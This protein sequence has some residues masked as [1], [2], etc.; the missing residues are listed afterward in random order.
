MRYLLILLLALNCYADDK[1]IYLKFNTGIDD[2][3]G[4]ARLLAVGY[5]APFYKILD[6]QLEG[7]A[8]RDSHQVQSTIAYGSATLGFTVNAQSGTYAKIFAG[9]ALVSSTDSRL[10]SI[11]EFNDDLELG[12]RDKRGLAL[13][14]S[15]KHISNAGLVPPNT[16]RDFVGFK[17][18]LPF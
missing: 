5:Q 12:I 9:P 13:G 10:S 2:K 16:G 15:F 3:I 17:V 8:F 6:Y 1:D 11:F 4:S 18:Q 14:I 7:G